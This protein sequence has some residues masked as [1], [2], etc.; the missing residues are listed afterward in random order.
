MLLNEHRPRQHTNST[1]MLNNN[2][3]K[4][5]EQQKQQKISN[6]KNENW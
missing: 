5:H 1:S 4:Q 2:N 3:D 6:W